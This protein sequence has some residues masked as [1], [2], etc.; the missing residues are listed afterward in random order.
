MVL[1]VHQ[2]T[3]YETKIWGKKGMTEQIPLIFFKLATAMPN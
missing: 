1:I 2:G 3:H